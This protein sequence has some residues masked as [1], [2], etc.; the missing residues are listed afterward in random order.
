VAAAIRLKEPEMFGHRRPF[1]VDAGPAVLQDP[2][3]PFDSR[4]DMVVSDATRNLG[5]RGITLWTFTL[6][7]QNPRVAFRTVMCQTTY[8]DAAGAV[9][10]TRQTPIRNIWQPGE[11]RQVLVNDGVIGRPFATAVLEVLD[12]EALLPT[13]S[14]N[15]PFQPR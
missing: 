1:A 12:A 2:A 13:P 14:S 15:N 9:M 8:R 3:R 5:V 11:S 10:D 7:N 4:Q 6:R